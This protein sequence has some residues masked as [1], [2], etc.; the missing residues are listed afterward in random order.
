MLP[1]KA[2]SVSIYL[3]VLLNFCDAVLSDYVNE[4]QRTTGKILPTRG[5]IHDLSF[6]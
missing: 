3:A 6:A 5:N 1:Y 2:F 4:F